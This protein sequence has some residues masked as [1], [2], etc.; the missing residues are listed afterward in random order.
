M[1][2]R[3]G[4]DRA[5]LGVRST[6]GDPDTRV[7]DKGA[8]TQ[9]IIAARRRRQPG[10]LRPDSAIDFES[11]TA[12]HMAS[13]SLSIRLVDVE[14]MLDRSR[15]RFE[16][17]TK[18]VEEAH[19]ALAEI[20]QALMGSP[21]TLSAEDSEEAASRLLASLKR[22]GQRNARDACAAGGWRSTRSSA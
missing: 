7:V 12:K 1:L 16:E 18:L 15:R 9:A 8:A 20:Q 21:V 6:A 14:S 13:D 2:E 19:A 10:R 4:R 3:A 17:G 11:E 22:R 5:A